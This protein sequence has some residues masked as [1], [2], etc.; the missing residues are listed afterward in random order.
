MKY[1]DG[2]SVA[3][4]YDALNRLHKLGTLATISYTLDDQVASIK[5]GDGQTA[6]YTYNSRDEP[7]SIMVQLGAI[8][9]LDLNYSY[10]NVGNVKKI[11]TEIYGYDYLNRLTSSNGPWGSITYTYDPVGNRLT[12]VQGGSK[13]SYTYN[14]VNELTKAGK[15]TYSYDANGN[16]VQE[17]TGGTTWKYGYDYENQLISVT[18]VTVKSSSVVQRNVYDGQ[19]QRIKEIEGSTTTVYMYQGTNIVYYKAGSIA[20]K[21]FYADGMA[22]ARIT[23][24]TTYYYHGDELGSIRLASTS[25][26]GTSFSSNYEPYGPEYGQTGSDAFMYTDKLYDTSTSLYYS[27]ARF[28]DPTTGRFITRDST[29]GSLSDPQSLNAYAYA[30]D[31]PLTN[32]DPTGHFSLTTIGLSLIVAGLVVV[33]VLQGGLDP[34]SDTLTFE[35]V[36]EL[37]AASGAAAS[38]AVTSATEVAPQIGD[39]TIPWATQLEEEEF[40]TYEQSVIAA[41]PK[42]IGDY[43]EEVVKGYLQNLGLKFFEQVDF[44]SSFGPRSADF[45]LDTLGDIRQLAVEVKTGGPEG[46]G[47]GGLTAFDRGQLGGY[48]DAVSRGRFGGV[49]YINVP[50]G[51]NYGFSESLQGYLELYGTAFKPLY[52]PL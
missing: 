47:E 1:P 42:A 37:L 7:T 14:N 33:D 49:L 41:G 45:V 28:Y 13:T 51:G 29:L 52:Y 19:G 17:I 39:E 34:A 38:E 48:L 40:A 36:S 11:G 21:L 50:I 25:G 24:S 4:T 10:D 46:W 26:G 23:G 2:Y 16:L 30:R 44:R 12:M 8:K 18:K 22:I 6:T 9:Q 31:N 5:Y 35:A 15:T 3:M 32:I 20:T 43:G 27:G